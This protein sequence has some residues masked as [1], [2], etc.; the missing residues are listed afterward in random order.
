M[1]YLKNLNPLILWLLSLT[2]LLLMIALPGS[3]FSL[4]VFIPITACFIFQRRMMEIVLISTIVLGLGLSKNF[5]SLHL[6]S[7]HSSDPLKII[8]G[9]GELLTS[10]FSSMSLQVAGFVAYLLVFCFVFKLYKYFFKRVT[11]QSGFI[12]SI[13]IL[14]LI[15]LSQV[16]LV[17]HN[18]A[19]YVFALAMLIM[20]R[21]AFY[22]FNY[23][24]FFDKLSFSK[25][26]MSSMLQPFWFLTFE[27][28]ENPTVKIDKDRD[29]FKK[30]LF[31]T[32]SIFL[33][34]L[35]FKILLTIYMTSLNFYLTRHYQLIID[36]AQLVNNLCIA[37][38]KNWRS[39]NAVNLLLCVFSYSLS[40]LISNFF[41][42]GRV[43]VGIARLCGFNLP[44]YINA[45]WKSSSFADF[46]SRIMYYYNIIIINHFF[47]PALEFLRRFKIKKET[48]I[49]ISLN[50]ALIFGGFFARFLK[51][52]WKVYKY[53]FV[54][55]VLLTLKLAL[56]YMVVLSLAVSI[57]LH[58]REKHRLSD[59]TNVSK[60][61]LYILI[62][63]FIMPLNFSIIFGNSKDM[64]MFYFKIITFGLF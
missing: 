25:E 41:I 36:D 37:I 6:F 52:I 30:G 32:F 43:V 62:Y 11:L 9:K 64:I 23:V 40:Y 55:A 35:F 16:A 27:I 22:I 13:F 4:Y 24:L 2:V 59:K 33:S 60:M 53:G 56:P 58:F 19:A 50:W 26:A 5:Y 51:D 3:P 54:E 31:D 14:C 46:F 17:A 45:P 48:R 10:Q 34:I 7:Y 29:E 8:S 21:Q 49:F 38:F 39:E 28:P 44:D 63:S 61:F 47:Y 20:G 15:W 18:E 12:L 1:L 42:Y 57:S